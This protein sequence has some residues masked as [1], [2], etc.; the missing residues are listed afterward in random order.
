MKRGVT[1][2]GECRVAQVTFHRS[3]IPTGRLVKSFWSIVDKHS[4]SR[5]EVHERW[6]CWLH[7][8]ASVYGAEN[9]VAQL[10]PKS[11]HSLVVKILARLSPVRSKPAAVNDRDCGAY[12]YCLLLYDRPGCR[13][14]QSATVVGTKT[15]SSR[16]P[17]QRRH[18]Y[19]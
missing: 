9:K 13:G 4:R 18:Q 5:T 15:T 10:G 3:T 11:V 8:C 2:H 7:V 1:E 6:Q 16:C 14:R 12:H 17:G 19:R